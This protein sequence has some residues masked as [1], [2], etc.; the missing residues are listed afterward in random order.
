VAQTADDLTT[1][2]LLCDEHARVS[3]LCKSAPTAREL[4]HEY[5]AKGWIPWRCWQLEISGLLTTLSAARRFFWLR[6]PS[7]RHHIDWPNSRAIRTG[8]PMIRGDLNYQDL[9]ARGVPRRHAGLEKDEIWPI[10]VM[11]QPETKITAKLIRL[12]PGKVDEVL[13]HVG[14]LP[15]TAEVTAATVEANTKPVAPTEVTKEWV[16]AEMARDQS[17]TDKDGFAKKIYGRRPAHITVTLKRVQNLVAEF[18]KTFPAGIPAA[19]KGPGK[20]NPPAGSS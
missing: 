6:R 7:V 1:W 8:P 2:P 5:L 9:D 3:E 4:L 10:F 17:W 11:D 19:G 14:L 18:K 15:P 16:F 12:H 13:R 20:G